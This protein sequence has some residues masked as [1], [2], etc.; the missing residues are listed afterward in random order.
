[1][2]V[3]GRFEWKRIGAAGLFSSF[4]YICIAIGDPVIKTGGFRFNPSTFVCLSPTSYVVC[5][6]PIVEYL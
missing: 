5:Y 2:M 3:S 4:V 1:M 6:V